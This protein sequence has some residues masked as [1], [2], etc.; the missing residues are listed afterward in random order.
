MGG[1]GGKGKNKL[2]DLF[3]KWDTG[4]QDLPD[5]REGLAQNM[6]ERGRPNFDFS[7]MGAALPL[8]GHVDQ[9]AYSTPP[10]QFNKEF[11]MNW[12]KGDA[13]DGSNYKSAVTPSGFDKY[14]KGG[15]KY[16]QDR[17]GNSGGGGEDTDGGSYES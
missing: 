17:S 4:K 1:G 2:F 13:V 5:T 8:A 12:Q 3:N 10:P 15:S 7:K 9:P 14:M 16:S 6:M 11:W